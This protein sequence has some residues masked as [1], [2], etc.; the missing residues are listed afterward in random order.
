MC[1]QETVIF[2]RRPLYFGGQHKTYPAKCEHSL[3]YFMEPEIRHNWK[4][5][6]QSQGIRD[7]CSARQFAAMVTAIALLRHRE[8]MINLNQF[9]WDLQ[10]TM[11]IEIIFL[12]TSL[13]AVKTYFFPQ[14]D[15]MHFIS[16][17]SK[18]P[19]F[20]GKLIK[21]SVRADV[22]CQTEIDWLVKQRK[23]QHL[24]IL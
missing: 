16:F 18:N 9:S 13:W 22:K 12:F 21:W 2:R 15:V 7:S 8:V 1:G 19:E 17:A 14:V 20:K 5:K 4:V 6:S 23:V 24:Y 10:A 3:S 11:I